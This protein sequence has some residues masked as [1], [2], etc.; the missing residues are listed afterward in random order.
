MSIFQQAGTFSGTV[1]SDNRPFCKTAQN[2]ELVS[3]PEEALGES[4]NEADLE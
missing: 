1:G 3:L 2:R 4:G